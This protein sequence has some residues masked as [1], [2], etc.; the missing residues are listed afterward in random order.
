MTWLCGDK[1][2]T[3][4]Q[5][6]IGD[7]ACTQ[8]QILCPKIWLLQGPH[9]YQ[10]LFCKSCSP[11]TGEVKFE[12]QAWGSQ[13]GSTEKEREEKEKGLREEDSREQVVSISH[14]GPAARA[15]VKRLPRTPDC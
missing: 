3:I 4:K 14:D 10:H 12:F 11:T 13:A 6:T 7:V 2:Y 15:G 5:L 9:I 1:P 8:C